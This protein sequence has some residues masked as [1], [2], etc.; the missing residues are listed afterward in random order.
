M[1]NVYL[2]M[3]YSLFVCSSACLL[4]GLR[5]FN[6][7]MLLR[8]LSLQETEQ[9]CPGRQQTGPAAYPSL[10]PYSLVPPSSSLLPST[11]TL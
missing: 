11:V 9:N 3:I 10:P 4:F 2:A 7:A 6:M 5:C 8:H 1:M